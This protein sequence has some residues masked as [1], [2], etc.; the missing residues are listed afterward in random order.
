MSQNSKRNH[1]IEKRGKCLA[2]FSRQKGMGRLYRYH[3]THK[4][5]LRDYRRELDT[6]EV[7]TPMWDLRGWDEVEDSLFEL[8][9]LRLVA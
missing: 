4:A 9:R 7:R 6:D 5:E 1:R 8:L 2:S 3:L